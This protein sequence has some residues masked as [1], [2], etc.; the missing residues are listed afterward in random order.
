VRI[1]ISQTA[2]YQTANHI[3]LYKTRQEIFTV[4]LRN[5]SAM[6]P[7][8]PLPTPALRNVGT[9]TIQDE[10]E[11]TPAPPMSAQAFPG[12]L[13]T[14]LEMA[15]QNNFEDIVSWQPCGKAF[16][17]HDT[18]RF[19]ESIMPTY[20]NQTKYKSFLRQVNIYGFQR[21]IRGA[22]NGAYTHNFLV[23]GEPEICQHMIR[24]KIKNKFQRSNNRSKKS[25][26]SSLVSSS[27]GARQEQ[28]VA[29]HQLSCSLS[30]MTADTIQM[31]SSSWNQHS[32]TYHNYG[33]DESEDS[34]GLL[35]DR[36]RIEPIK[37]HDFVHIDNVGR[38][39]I[40]NT[41]LAD[42]II[43]TFCQDFKVHPSV[44]NLVKL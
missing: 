31:T 40:S 37:L 3:A 17:V 13:H 4:V 26:S 20:F 23:R 22:E 5:N 35:L 6:V 34:F 15:S 10:A 36:S 41:E 12:R 14:M 18:K 1:I 29:A 25:S 28:I 32:P 44:M 39:L 42:E 43:R 7:P 21:L 2:D 11:S 33:H 24:T 19:A 38:H 9:H 16:K 27:E 8:S 30:T